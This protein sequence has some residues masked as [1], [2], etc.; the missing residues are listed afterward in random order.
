MDLPSRFAERAAKLLTQPEYVH[1]DTCGWMGGDAEHPCTC[2]APDLLRAIATLDLELLFDYRDRVHP[3]QDLPD[4]TSS[5]TPPAKGTIDTWT[6]AWTAVRFRTHGAWKIGV[7]RGKIRLKASGW[8]VE[9]E[10]GHDG[11]HPGWADRAWVV[12]DPRLIRP[13][14]NEPP[15]SVSR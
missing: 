4:V 10:T 6:L 3:D 1:A 12:W 7:V 5:I 14:E 15:A 11:M 13:I 8:I 9:I 2:V